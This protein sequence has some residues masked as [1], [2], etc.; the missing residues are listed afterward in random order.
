MSALWV[1]L[2]GNICID[3]EEDEEERWRVGVFVTSNGLGG[4]GP[5]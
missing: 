1:G 3:M 2:N 4:E 5:L